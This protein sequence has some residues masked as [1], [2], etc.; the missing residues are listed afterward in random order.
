MDDAKQSNTLQS[1]TRSSFKKRKRKRQSIRRI[2]S[3]DLSSLATNTLRMV[4]AT[5]QISSLMN[6][7]STNND[8]DDDD[9]GD[10]ISFNSQQ[11]LAHIPDIVLNNL[12]NL[13]D[14]NGNTRIPSEHTYQHTTLLFLD[15]SGFTV[16]TEQYSNDAH[17]G[18]DQLTH[19][20]NTYFDRL[21][22]S[23]LLHYGDIYKFAGDA[24][25]ALW[26]N[27]QT[28]PEQALKCAI[29]LQEKFGTYQTDIGVVLRL[30]IALAYGCVQALFIGTDEFKHYILTG[31]CVKHVNICEQLCVAGDIIL[32]KSVYDRVRTSS[33]CCEF[34]PI[35]DGEHIPVKYLESIDNHISGDDDD[36]ER[37]RIQLNERLTNSNFDLLNENHRSS[38]INSLMN[39]DDDF[40]TKIDNLIPSFLLRCVYQR[41]ERRQS[42][43]YLSELRRVTIT[44]INLDISNEQ[45]TELNLQQSMQ[46]IFIDIYELTK[47]MGGVLTKGLVFD[48]GWSFLCVFG[49]PGYKQ[50]DDTANALKCAHM[51]HSTLTKQHSLIRQ[52]SI[53]VCL[54]ASFYC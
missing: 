32:T 16:L 19:T 29:N 20:L 26:T 24:I 48:K 27:E 21:V 22:S 40:C 7:N 1:K 12:N 6:S 5:L 15:V 14:S 17:L 23:I 18:I 45:S 2:W 28:G 30:K 31:D 51:I 9:E 46:Q 50:G 10:D 47:M 37:E 42:L 34:R 49:L 41:I 8:D 52:C 13:I 53:G 35:D 44:F 3:R 25:L 38:S 33:Y 54:F 43:D 39:V 11:I 4:I 36:D